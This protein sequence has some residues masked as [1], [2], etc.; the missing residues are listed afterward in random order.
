M[1]DNDQPADLSGELPGL[2]EPVCKIARQ[3]GEEILKVYNS[4]FAVEDKADGSP[5][6]AA[7]RAAHQTIVSELAKLTPAMPILSEEASDI[8]YA[9]RSQWQRYWLV[10]PLDGTKEFV[11]RNGEF[12][13]NIALIENGEPV[14]GVVYVPVSGVIY[15]GCRGSGAF[16]QTRDGKAAAITVQ[17][18]QGGPA[19]VVASRSHASPALEQFLD[20]VGEVETISMGS[21][22]KLCLV[23]EGAADVYP[24]LGLTSEWDTAAAQAVV[25]TAGGKVTTVNGEPLVYNKEDILNPWFVVS[26]GKTD[27]TRFLNALD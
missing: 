19:R 25:E 3:A 10:D 22:L 8:D 12:T 20:A 9:V 2:L 6:T 23:A 17:T 11:K 27:W 7:D 1:E 13:V 14:L 16:K 18:Y 5:L 4:D 21:S 15:F 24:R 26:D